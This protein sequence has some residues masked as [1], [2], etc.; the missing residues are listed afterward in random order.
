MI[1]NDGKK[2]H[3][4]AV[5]SISGLFR[6]IK[7]ND[8]G[9]FCYLICLHSYRTKEQLKKHEKRYAIIMIIVM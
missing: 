5:K 2:R 1:T 8:H 4:L 3:Y 9:D 7:S 6:G